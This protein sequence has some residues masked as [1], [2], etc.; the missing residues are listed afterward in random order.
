MG[1]PAVKTPAM[2]TLWGAIVA[3]LVLASPALAQTPASTEKIAVLNL[4]N[5]ANLTETEIVYLTD[6][7]RGGALKLD[8]RRYLVMTRENILEMLPP[9]VDL[10]SCE[11]QCEV[12]T[13]RNIGADYV[14]TG[15][16]IRF[17]QALKVSMRLYDTRTS[18]LIGQAS[19]SAKEV[20]TLEQPVIRATG[21]LLRP[22]ER[23]ADPRVEVP[24]KTPAPRK[25]S[26]STKGRAPWPTQRQVAPWILAVS[27]GVLILGGVAFATA[28]EN[29]GRELQADPTNETLK[30]EV[31]GT[32][33][34][35]RGMYAIGGVVLAAGVLWI[36]L[37]GDEPERA[38]GPMVGPGMVGWSGRW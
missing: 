10:A 5:G 15:E 33:T 12:E 6:Q 11:G 14:A 2:K 35:S 20:D 4:G 27:G 7:I 19:A 24:M 8:Q 29:A 30:E 9:G 18:A 38:S 37:E 32:Y 13:G 1:R 34:V 36:L 31:D 16:I 23:A 26:V 3:L 17:G 25:R 21:R 22:L 28:N